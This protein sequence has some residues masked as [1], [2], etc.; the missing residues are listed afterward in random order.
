MGAGNRIQRGEKRNHEQHQA[1]AM[2]PRLLAW[3]TH[4]HLVW[5]APPT[6][7][8]SEDGSWPSTRFRV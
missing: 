8:L 4:K 2:C 7:H 6:V 1:H 5:L 3:T